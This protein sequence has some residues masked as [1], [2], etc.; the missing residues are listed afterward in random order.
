LVGIQWCAAALAATT[1]DAA[2]V[3][4]GTWRKRST[5]ARLDGL[6][7]GPRPGRQKAELVLTDEERAQ[8]TR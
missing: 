5:Q 3:T 1:S 4:V 8:L 6:A 7:D 2:S